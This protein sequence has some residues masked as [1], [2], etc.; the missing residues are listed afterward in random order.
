MLAWS[1]HAA[2]DDLRKKLVP[3]AKYTV[4][5]L[6]TGLL[7]ALKPRPARQRTLMLA[8]TLI[9]GV[10]DSPEDARK[11][12]AFV[13]PIVDVVQKVNVDLIPVNPTD[14][15]PDFLRPSDAALELFRDAIRE[16]EPRV[17]VALRVTRGDDKTAACGQLHI[18]RNSLSEARAAADA[19]VD[20]GDQQPRLV[21]R[22][23]VDR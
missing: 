9:A 5:E 12:A 13:S 2:D 11:L 1:V 15:A 20:A 14:H 16:V 17:H 4:D 21:L 18:R 23:K 22:R 3:S 8:A 19:A 7:D 6:R 10:N